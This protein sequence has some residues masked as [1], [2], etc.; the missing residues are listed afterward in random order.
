MKTKKWS[1]DHLNILNDQVFPQMG[2]SPLE[3]TAY[4]EMTK[5]V[6][7]RLRLQ[8][9]S[10]GRIRHHFHIG[11]HRV[12]TVIPVSIFWMLLR[13]LTLLTSPSPDITKNKATQYIKLF[14]WGSGVSY[15]IFLLMLLYFKLCVT[16]LRV[17]LHRKRKGG[18]PINLSYCVLCHA[19]H[20]FFP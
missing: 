8:K 11:L 12:Q 14:T 9:S 18:S 13:G 20:L 5:L 10:W 19:I 1:F 3:S 6:L 2:F 15:P 4:S 17:N 7:I 16:G